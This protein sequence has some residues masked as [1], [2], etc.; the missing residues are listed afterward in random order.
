MR[1]RNIWRN[2]PRRCI[3]CQWHGRVNDGWPNKVRRARRKR[4]RKSAYMMNSK[5]YLTCI[6]QERT[7]P[8]NALQQIRSFFFRCWGC[9]CAFTCA[10]VLITCGCTFYHRTACDATRLMLTNVVSSSI[11]LVT[12]LMLLKLRQACFVHWERCRRCD[13]AGNSQLAILVKIRTVVSQLVRVTLVFILV[14]NGHLVSAGLVAAMYSRSKKK[15]K[16]KGNKVLR[17]FI[18]AA[19][20]TRLKRA[21]DDPLV[22]LS[23]GNVQ[24]SLESLGCVLRFAQSR[25]FLDFVRPILCSI[26]EAEG[27]RRLNRSWTRRSRTPTP[28]ASR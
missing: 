5:I 18:A 28:R 26:T 19:A 16:E 14:R 27:A 15:K 23:G 7:R 21:R 8:H 11:I 12:K 22:T 1:S 20:S 24:R 9:N 25:S 2:F 3:C 4:M 13:Q 10:F 17:L 6:A